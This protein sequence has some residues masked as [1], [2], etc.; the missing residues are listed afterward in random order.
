MLIPLEH[1]YYF[2]W[3]VITNVASRILDHLDKNVYPLWLYDH[4][5]LQEAVTRPRICKY[6]VV[7]LQKSETCPQNVTSLDTI[8]SLKSLAS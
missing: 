2:K 6:I 1:N 3:L 8:I 7:S 5:R 4:Q